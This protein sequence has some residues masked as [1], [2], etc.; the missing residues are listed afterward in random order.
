[1]ALNTFVEAEIWTLAHTEQGNV[2]LVKPKDSE[3]VV[4][5]F[6]GQLET[7]SILIGL[8]R[9]E[10]PRPLTHDLILALFRE[11]SVELERIEIHD[12]KEGT[13][14]ARLV[15]KHGGDTVLVDSRPSDAI[16]LAVRS[17]CRVYVAENVVEESGISVD[18]VTEAVDRAGA[19]PEGGEP[20]AEDRTDERTDDERARLEKELAEAVSEEDYE[21]AAVLRDR[22]KALGA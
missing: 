2:V 13:F 22:I 8:G 12:L 20:Q 17:G 5:I 16:G 11:F 6:I 18:L 9:L 14:Y 10:M 4:P 21:R 1:M 3:V 7:Q 19:T 15:L